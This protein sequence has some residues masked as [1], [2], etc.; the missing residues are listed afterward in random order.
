[1]PLARNIRKFKAL[2]WAITLNP[3]HA[4]ATPV[5]ISCSTQLCNLEAET[6]HHGR[7]LTGLTTLLRLSA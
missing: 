5:S 4:Y 7:S 1:M 2:V 3:I 6:I